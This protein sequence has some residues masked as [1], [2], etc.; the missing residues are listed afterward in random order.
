MFGKLWE[1]PV[2]IETRGLKSP[3]IS[4]SFLRNLMQ[5]WLE[6]KVWTYL[7]ETRILSVLSLWLEQFR[8]WTVTG[9]QSLHICQK[10]ERIW[11]APAQARKPA[12]PRSA[13]ALALWVTKLSIV[14]SE[15]IA[16]DHLLQPP[17]SPLSQVRLR[18]EDLRNKSDILS[19]SPCQALAT[20]F[21][22]GVPHA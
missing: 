8:K 21:Q 10:A 16:A 5:K 22:L 11:K 3:F 17:Q 2:A 6:L 20:I 15:D 13:R 1:T 7:W 4:C 18:L 9:R 14:S 19:L 12:V